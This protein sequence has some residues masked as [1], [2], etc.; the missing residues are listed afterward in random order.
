VTRPLALA[1]LLALAAAP[2]A[3]AGEDVVPL[4]VEVG[5]SVALCK[6]GTIVCPAGPA[7][8]EDLTVVEAVGTDAGVA[9]RGKKPGRTRCSAR[10]S[11]GAGR[12]WIYEVEVVP[13]RK[14]QDAPGKAPGAATPGD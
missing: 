5:R 3:V 10:A 9:L 6:T 4:E 12:L 11:G 2:S 13:P 14:K 7:F 8:C 1:A